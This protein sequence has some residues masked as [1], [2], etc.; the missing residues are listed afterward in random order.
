[1]SNI[2]TQI[3]ENKHP[4]DVHNFM[5][6]RKFIDASKARYLGLTY[7]KHCQD[8][9]LG[10][11]DGQV[12]DAFFTYNYKPF[13][14]LLCQKIDQMSDLLGEQVIPTYSY[15]RVYKRGSILPKHIDR[16]ECEIS[17]TIHLQGDCEWPINIITP[18]G[19]TV[20]IILGPGDALVYKGNVAEHW[21]NPFPGSWY[22]QVFL[23][24]V[25][26]NGQHLD[27]YFDR[28][29]DRFGRKN[30]LNDDIHV[31][32]SEKY[33]MVFDNIIPK[34]VCDDVI[35]E[36]KNSFEFEDALL[37]GGVV[38]K[39]IR[40]C[41]TLVISNP[42]VIQKNKVVREKIDKQLY[43]CLSLATE[44]YCET[45]RNCS[46]RKDDGFVLLCYKKGEF[47][48]EHTDNGINNRTLT[49]I[50]ILNDDYEGGKLRFFSGKYTPELKKG[51]II[52]FPSAFMF[53][54]EVTE[55]TSGV[56]YSI[57][58]WIS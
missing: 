17:V 39:T 48:V 30:I 2:G 37:I 50:M 20:S 40:N 31:D 25:K 10:S 57:V 43:K 46:I 22:A 19:E 9:D 49:C 24:Y 7:K 42:D 55:V 32:N 34:E 3:K 1:M 14:E 5:I 6:I 44:K 16:P 36:Y 27:R 58:S 15:S 56:R 18:S 12:K 33:I 29:F 47:Y 26:S 13:L 28:Y 45:Y 11:D 4:L 21:R 52:I 23:H 8:N 38:D 41:N 53:P 35:N 51:S 54:H